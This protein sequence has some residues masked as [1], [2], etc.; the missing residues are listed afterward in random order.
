MDIY[1]LAKQRLNASGVHAIYGGQ[2]CTYRDERFYS[3]RQAC[4]Q[5]QGKTG[6]LASMIW[7]DAE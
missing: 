1:T 6:R 3:Y 5:T 4:Q 2:Y 7:I